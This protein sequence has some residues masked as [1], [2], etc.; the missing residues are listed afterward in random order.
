VC[1]GAGYVVVEPQDMWWVDVWLFLIPHLRPSY[2]KGF[3][4]GPSVAIFVVLLAGMG[5]ACTIAVI[6]YIWKS[7]RLEKKINIRHSDLVKKAITQTNTNMFYINRN[8]LDING[9]GTIHTDHCHSQV[10]I[11]GKDS[12]GFLHHKI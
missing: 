8:S 11:Y 7:R 1:G 2:R 4:S 3:P 9:R 10:Q 5:I 6:K 12:T